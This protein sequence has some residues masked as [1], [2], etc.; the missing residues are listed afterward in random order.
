MKEIVS[1]GNNR[2]EVKETIGQADGGR[3][4]WA[5]SELLCLQSREPTEVF[6]QSSVVIRLVS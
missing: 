4:W 1:F 3:S 2:N 6:K 5:L